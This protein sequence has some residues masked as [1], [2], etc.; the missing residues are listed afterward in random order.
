MRFSFRGNSQDQSGGRCALSLLGCL[1]IAAAAFLPLVSQAARSH[2][3]PAEPH[4]SPLWANL[5][6]GKYHVGFKY[7]Y[8]FDR[9]RTWTITRG[10][11]QPFSPDLQG[12]P[13][14]ISVWYPASGG[15]RMTYNDYVHGGAPPLFKT[16]D[17]IVRAQD[18]LHSRLN[19]PKGSLP[20]FLAT[21]V[22]AYSSAAP[23]N[24]RFPL[25]LYCD[26]LDGDTVSNFVLEE[27]L[28]S[29]GF[30]V[31]TMP[32][33]GPSSG[34]PTQNRTQP[35]LEATIRDMEFVW[36]VLRASPDVAPEEL[37]VMGHSVGAIE[38]VLFAMRNG[39]VSAVVGLDGTYGF[40][41]ATNVLTGFYDYNP[42]HMGSALLDLRRA[43][44]N[45]GPS[46]F[47]PDLSAVNA[48]HYSPRTLVTLKGMYHTDFTTFGI[49]AKEF[50][51]PPFADRNY[52]V[53]SA[54]YQSVCRIVRDF[55]QS[56]LIGDSGMA[57]RLSADVAS[58]PGGS[59]NR[60]ASIPLP[61][62]PQQLVAIA[63]DRGLDAAEEII[64]QYKRDAPDNV[65][66]SESDY[67]SLG[68]S[69]LAQKSFDKAILALL[70][71]CYVYPGSANLADSLGDMY[72][73][74]G[75]TAKARE[76]YRHALDLLPNDSEQNVA[77]KEDLK[78]TISQSI[79][80]LG[81]DGI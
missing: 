49:L 80:G 74:A 73:G 50:N 14:R 77:G 37:A 19:V 22:N 63:S 28:A 30:V 61:P 59:L 70:L 65:I 55:L 69:L 2:E 72:V 53:G 3:Q 67:N 34:S 36:S 45:V 56:V 66:V 46:A 44:T 48:L 40:Q 16:Y 75:Q 41:G 12:R 4:N 52:N 6:P 43:Q 58:A 42:L 60:V 17:A 81:P 25:V 24:Q 33:I 29:N 15:R 76:A 26:G 64:Q 27:Y 39:D 8:T 47:V 57:S 32:T 38:A 23:L 79:K 71:D 62:S 10:Y 11:D 7:I 13:I 20:Q 54:G 5:A 51:F 9:S 68:Y 21:P 35:D 18:L 78:Q 31:A 1:L